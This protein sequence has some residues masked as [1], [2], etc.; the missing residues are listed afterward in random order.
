[1]FLIYMFSVLL[2]LDLNFHYTRCQP[3]K[4]AAAAGKRFSLQKSLFCR[5]IIL[6]F[7]HLKEGHH[8]RLYLVSMAY[9]F[10][11]VLLF[12]LDL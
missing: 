6:L 1:M 10:L 9:L 12:W 7:T 5:I 2:F 8:A 3:Q 4:Q 11:S